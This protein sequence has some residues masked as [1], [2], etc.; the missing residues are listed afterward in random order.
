MGLVLRGRGGLFEGQGQ[1]C[2]SDEELSP[3]AL[4]T[5]V[6]LTGCARTLVR[7]GQ[8]VGA[9]LTHHES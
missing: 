9:R 3:A 1:Y 6:V 7:T 2:L 5:R 8:W 4:A